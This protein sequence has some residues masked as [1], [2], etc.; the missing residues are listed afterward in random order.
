MRRAGTSVDTLRVDGGAAVLDLL[1]QLQAD[2]LRTP[3]SRSA[4]TEA[5]A[6]GAATLA[7]L[8]EGVWSSIEE[9]GSLW[10][11]DRAFEPKASTVAANSAHTGWLAA[12]DRARHWATEDAAE[13]PG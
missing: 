12:V 6:L 10:S 2:Q 11:L 1:L 13:Q 5:T 4:T 3:V 9:L 7:G 8:A